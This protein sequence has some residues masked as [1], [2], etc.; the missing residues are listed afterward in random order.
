[1]IFIKKFINKISAV[2]GRQ[3]KDLVISLADARGLRDDL[4]KLLIDNY[5]LLKE[6]NSTE[7]VIQ[8]EIKG[9]TF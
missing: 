9:G 8:V 1:M 5:E 3:S 4:D 6:K 7:S 2:E